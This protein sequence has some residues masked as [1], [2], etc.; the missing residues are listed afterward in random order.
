[1]KIIVRVEPQSRERKIEKLG[2]L[3]YK[4][5]TTKP[6]REGRANADVIEILSKYFNVSKSSIE[7][8]SGHRGKEKIVIIEE[9]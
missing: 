2:A 6:A 1:M 8:V 4:V 7:I 3:C 9:L 5:R